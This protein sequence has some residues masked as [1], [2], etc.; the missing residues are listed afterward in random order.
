MKTSK[1]SDYRSLGELFFDE[2]IRIDQ[3]IWLAACG[4]QPPDA[5]EEFL[6]G[7]DAATLKRVLGLKKSQIE[8]EDGEPIR[9]EELLSTIARSGKQGF[10]VQAATPIP[11]A[12]HEDGHSSHGFGWCQ[13]EW[14]YTETLDAPFV[15]RLLDW[16]TTV[17]EATR[18][19]LAK[20]KNAA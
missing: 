6:E 9:A 18:K 19:K 3:I 7:E 8:D 11:T 1:I 4:D 5:L 15:Q 16:K 12:F 13:L 2:S 10:L 14:F 20:K 17:I